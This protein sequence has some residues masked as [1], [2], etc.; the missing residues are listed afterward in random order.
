MLIRKSLPYALAQFCVIAFQWA[1]MIFIPL[2]FRQQGLSAARIGALIALFDFSTLLLVFPLGALSDRIPPR[3]LMI[4]GGVLAAV[5]G[6][7]LPWRT[8]L[9]W[10]A[11][12]MAIAGAAFTLSSIALAALFFKQVGEDRRGAEVAVFSVGGVMGAGVGAWLCGQLMK[13]FAVAQVLFPAAAGFALGWAL[14]ALLLPSE[15]GLS[16]PLIEYGRDL[17]RGATWVLIAIM[18]VTASHSGFEHSGYTLLQTEVLHLSAAMIGNL[19]IIIAVWMGLISVW[20]GRRH[21]RAERPLLMI[22]LA[23]LISG[24]FMA[25][26]GSA[27]GPLDFLAYRILHTTG[28]AVFNLLIMV[29]AAQIFPKHRVGGA[30]AFALTINTASYAGFALLG[31][32]VGQRYGFDRAFHLGGAIEILGGTLLLAF[33]PRLRRSFRIEE[34]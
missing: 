8:T 31:G 19:F 23:L 21:D 34:A 5:A 2:Y 17:K 33:R 10:M 30:Y 28:D 4:A 9:L 26:S 15:Q 6:A 7:A 18:V 24:A 29:L 13:R 32:L 22:G 16:F 25:A 20:A 12:W 1:A 3:P 27:R 11:L 14:L